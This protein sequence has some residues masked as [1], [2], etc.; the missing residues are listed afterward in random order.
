MVSPSPGSRRCPPTWPRRPQRRSAIKSAFRLVFISFWLVAWSFGVAWIQHAALTSGGWFDS[1][2]WLFVLTHGGGEVAVIYALTRNLIK[3]A[4][5]PAML[6]ESVDLGQVSATWRE[7]SANGLSVAIAGGVPLAIYPV[8]LYPLLTVLVNPAS[9]LAAAVASL[10]VGVWLATIAM[11]WQQAWKAQW[12]GAGRVELEVDAV[13]LSLTT[14]RL[15]WEQQQSWPLA[16]VELETKRLGGKTTLT[17][18]GEGSTWTGPIPQ[19][20]TGLIE[21][22]EAVRGRIEDR[23]QGEVPAELKAL[24]GSERVGS[25]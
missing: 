12:A 4:A 6:S 11:F 20:V 22:V 2:F 15:W 7:G 17:I 25:E 23:S 9:V 19:E 16:A 21:Q 24:R 18:C 14:R 10:L 1:M 3:Q 5:E 8:L 13:R